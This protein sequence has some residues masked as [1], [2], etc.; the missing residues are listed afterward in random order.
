MLLPR[1]GARHPEDRALIAQALEVYRNQDEWV[2]AQI[3]EALRCTP[4]VGDLELLEELKRAKASYVVY[5]AKE[6]RAAILEALGMP[7]DPKED[8]A[9]EGDEVAPGAPKSEL[10]EWLDSD[11]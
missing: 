4:E 7:P 6:A 1:S 5:F 2:G 8:D 11:D 10:D 9:E 3:C